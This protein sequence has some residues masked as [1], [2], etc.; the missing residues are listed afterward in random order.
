MGLVK[1]GWVLRSARLYCGDPRLRVAATF[2]Q[3]NE[4]FP[5]VHRSQVSRWENGDIAPSLDLVRRYESVCGM[6]PGQLVSAIDLVNRDEEPFRPGPT[7]RRPPSEDRF[8]IAEATLHAAITD[9]PISGDNWDALSALLGQNPTTLL[10]DEH[11]EK[12]IIRGLQEMDVSVGLAYQQR[13]EAMARI[14]SHPR[15]APRVISVVR[16]VLGD[17]AAQVYSEAA[18]LL[19]CCPHHDAGAVLA[20]SVRDPVNENALRAALFS[21][22]ALLRRGRASKEVAVDLV[23]AALQ[24]CRDESM[25]YRV[26]RAAADLLLALDTTTRRRLSATLRSDGA[27]EAIASIVHGDGPRPLQLLRGLRHRVRQRLTHQ[28]GPRLE[29]EEPLL[30]LVDHITVETN[31]EQRGKTLQ[32]L[33]LLPFGPAVGR[34]YLAELR[35]ALAQGDSLNVHEALSILLCL[36]PADSTEPVADVAVRSCAVPDD[37]DELAVEACWALGNAK[38]TPATDSERTIERVRTAVVEVL[39]GDQTASVR[40][41]EGWG[42]VLGIRGAYDVLEHLPPNGHVAEAWEH[43]RRWWLDLPAALRH[44]ATEDHARISPRSPRR[45][46]PPTAASRSAHRR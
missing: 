34:A 44:A 33:M 45:S 18:A 16:R 19:L 22:A 20:A 7:L 1:P 27:E 37:P 21:S 43:T 39:D 15:A 30:R 26:R 23:R 32:L 35:E 9:S 41:L 24:H 2:A 31:D 13:S 38:F 6:P 12:L 46:P 25:T 28:L 10:L 3:G 42:Y 14:A 29:E 4:W 11:W 5:P 36:T 17:P 40:L 8:D